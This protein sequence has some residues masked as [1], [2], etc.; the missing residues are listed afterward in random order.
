[1]KLLKAAKANAS[2][3]IRSK[4]G[5][6]KSDMLH[7]KKESIAQVSLYDPVLLLKKVWER[8]PSPH[9]DVTE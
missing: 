7:R 8:Q 4:N 2:S 9:L 1:M 5:R 3:P 6:A